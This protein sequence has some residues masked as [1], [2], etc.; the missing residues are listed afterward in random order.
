MFY[1]A[2]FYLPAGSALGGVAQ[3]ARAGAEQAAG[4][5]IDIA[6]VAAR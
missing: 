1:L 3:R 5:G 2:E 4:T 6:F